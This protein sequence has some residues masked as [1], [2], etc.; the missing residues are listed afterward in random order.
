MGILRRY[1]TVEYAEALMT[2]GED[3]YRR[4]S[5]LEGLY[6]RGF[7]QR[8]GTNREFIHPQLMIRVTSDV[9]ASVHMLPALDQMMARKRRELGI[10]A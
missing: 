5:N 1:D 6:A 3:E 7:K 8:F 2:G 10:D 9:L 4:M